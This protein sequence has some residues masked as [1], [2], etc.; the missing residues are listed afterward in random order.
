MFSLS[1]SLNSC[2]GC[3][4]SRWGCQWCFKENRCVSSGYLCSAFNNNSSHSPSSSTSSSLSTVIRTKESCPSF[5][6]ERNRSL[7]LSLPNGVQREITLPVQNLAF[8]EVTFG[9]VI[10]IEGSQN[11]VSARVENGNIICSSARFAYSN[12]SAT[13]L[14]TV[15]AVWNR[16]KHIDQVNGKFLL[17]YFFTFLFVFSAFF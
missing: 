13:G 6:L 11:Y 17:S 9:C 7:N 3:V 15:T 2:S 5:N 8:G 1:L 16:V 10:E 14:A 12:E 4:Q